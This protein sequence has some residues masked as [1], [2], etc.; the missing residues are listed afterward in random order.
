MFNSFLNDYN[1]KLFA[2]FALHFLSKMWSY[3][4]ALCCQEKCNT[5]KPHIRHVSK[6]NGPAPE[7]HPV[8]EGKLELTNSFLL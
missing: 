2:I 6:R 4:S 8:T 7:T 1:F 5:F 3:W